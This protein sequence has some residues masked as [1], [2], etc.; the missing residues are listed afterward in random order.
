[1][2][3]VFWR[4]APTVA[5]AARSGAGLAWAWAWAAKAP[6]REPAGFRFDRGHS[7]T[8]VMESELAAVA[9]LASDVVLEIISAECCNG[10]EL[11]GRT[12][13]EKLEF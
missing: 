9:E 1:M 6:A 13:F 8:A 7:H 12:N 3:F 2:R 5:E 11:S 4:Q 10:G